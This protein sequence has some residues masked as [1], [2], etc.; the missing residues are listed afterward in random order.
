MTQEQARTISEGAKI[1]DRRNGRILTVTG[2]VFGFPPNPKAPFPVTEIA[3]DLG[4]V[5]VRSA[6]AWNDG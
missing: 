2:R 5:P 4:Y 1:R 6:E 3:T